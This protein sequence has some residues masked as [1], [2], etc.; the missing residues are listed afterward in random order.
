MF[1]NYDKIG[2]FI[3]ELPNRFMARV[4]IDGIE[5]ICYVKS[6]SRLENYLTLKGKSVFLKSNKKSKFRYFIYSVKHR[7]SQILLCPTYANEIVENS[8]KRKVFSFISNRRNHVR[9]FNIHAYKS[10]IYFPSSHMF[11]E[12][13][14]IISYDEAAMFPTVYSERLS[15]QLCYFNE[16]FN[17]SYE[18]FL[19][20]VCFNPYTKLIRINETSVNYDNIINAISRGL[21]IKGFVVSY[22]SGNP[23]IKKEIPVLLSCNY[24]N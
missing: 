24:T 8:L 9:E 2:M 13:K 23:I 4:E 12:I 20:L 22:E 21:K 1:I 19:F 14:S 6:S 16:L 5:E 11:V 10:D 15:K 7:N 17:E 18:G 3:E